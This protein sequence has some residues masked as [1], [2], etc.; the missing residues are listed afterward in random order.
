MKITIQIDTVIL[1]LD[2][3]E[4]MFVFLVGMVIGYYEG[5]RRK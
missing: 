3:F 4:K 5:I 1:I 2:I